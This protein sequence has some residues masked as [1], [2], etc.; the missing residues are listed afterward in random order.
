MLKKYRASESQETKKDYSFSVLSLYIFL[1]GRDLTS[2]LEVDIS[3]IHICMPFCKMLLVSIS[4]LLFIIFFILLSYYFTF[5]LYTN[6]LLYNIYLSTHVLLYVTLLYLYLFRILV[7]PTSL[8][9]NK[10]EMLARVMFKMSVVK[11]SKVKKKNL[12]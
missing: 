11:E 12:V 9:Q 5:I 7:S 6:I 3:T 8:Q 4:V 2:E 1:Q 10:C